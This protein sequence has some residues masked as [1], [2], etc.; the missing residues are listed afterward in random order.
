M[1]ILCLSNNCLLVTGF[2]TETKFIASC[3]GWKEWNPLAAGDILHYEYRVR[4]HGTQSRF[5]FYYGTNSTSM[6]VDLPL[7]RDEYNMM[8]Q[9]EFAVIDGIHDPVIV[10]Q[11]VT[12]SCENIILC[13]IMKLCSICGEYTYKNSKIDIQDCLTL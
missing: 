8:N 12:V 6:P 2:A 3:E 1:F 9:I 11:N 7:G 13:V 5:L 10:K 4:V